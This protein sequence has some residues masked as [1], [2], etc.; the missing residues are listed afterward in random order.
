MQSPAVQAR[1]TAT[2][3]TRWSTRL[4][5]AACFMAFVSC[6]LD[7]GRDGPPGAPDG[8]LPPVDSARPDSSVP[9]APS[10]QAYIWIWRNYASNLDTVV[11]HAESFTRVSPALYQLN[12]DYQS[13]PA[14][15]LNENNDFDGMTAAQ[16]CQR[17]HDAQLR[18]EPLVYAG[19]GNY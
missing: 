6:H 15:L 3:R 7:A 1:R 9:P 17:A 19:A 18:C 12:F 10:R 14:R 13:G 2:M 16:L 8:S 5:A 4:L 11:A